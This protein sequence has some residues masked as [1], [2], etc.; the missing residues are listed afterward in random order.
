[1]ERSATK[2]ILP[3]PV[4]DELVGEL[5]VGATDRET[6]PLSSIRSIF[7]FNVKPTFCFSNVLSVLLPPTVSVIFNVIFPTT[8]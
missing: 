7:T 5:T 1:M 3:F 2:E 4:S 6:K 8:S